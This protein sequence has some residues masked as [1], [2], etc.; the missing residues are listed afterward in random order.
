MRMQLYRAKSRTETQDIELAMDMMIVFSK[1]DERKADDAIF[2]RL[3]KKLELHTMAE[4]RT[5]TMAVKKLLKNRTLQQS[6]GSIKQT[7]DLLGK[8]KQIAGI[9]ESSVLDGTESSKCLQK[10]QSFQIPHE[11]LCPI[12]LEIMTDPVIVA[13]GQVI[14]NIISYRNFDIAVMKFL[15]CMINAFPDL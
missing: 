4:L 10:C 15:I 12:S 6:S 7:M 9:E 8:F 2:E 11:F 14:L 1:N 13:T 3:A 5:E